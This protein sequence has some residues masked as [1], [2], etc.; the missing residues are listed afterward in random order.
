MQ[1]AHLLAR[2]Q[3]YYRAIMRGED[4]GDDEEEEEEEGEGSEDLVVVAEE[5]TTSTLHGHPLA[6]E[7][8]QK[9]GCHTVGGQRDR[10][11]F[12]MLRQRSVSGSFDQRQRVHATQRM[13]PRSMP[14]LAASGS[15]EASGGDCHNEVSTSR[16]LA[17]YD[18][19]VF[20]GKYSSDG[21]AFLS[22]CQD[23]HIRIYNAETWK[24]KKDVTARHFG[25]SILDV[26][27]SPD[28]RF[29]I[30]SSWADYIQLCNVSG[31]GEEEHSALDL[32]PQ[33]RRFCL[34]SIQ[35]SQSSSEILAGASDQCMYIYDLNT[36]ERV[37]R[38]LA[39]DDDVNAV[40]WADE[41]S[42][43]LF[44]GSDD[45]L[46]KVWD[47]RLLNQENPKPVGTLVGHLEGITHVCSKRDSRYLISNSKDQSIKLW[48]LRA[49][50]NSDAPRQGIRRHPWDYRYGDYFY[51]RHQRDIFSGRLKHPDD[52]SLKTYRGHRVFQTLIRCYFSPEHSTGQRYIYTGSYDGSVYVYDVISGEVV[53]KLHGHEATVRDVSWHPF[54]PN[55]VSTSWDGTVRMWQGSSSPL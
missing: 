35:F 23:R 16:L 33:A 42:Q 24:L 20:C 19:Q 40:S 27:Y 5:E 13:V 31:E 49:M 45:C 4:P 41:T 21:S 54:D 47:R 44:S 15:G 51:G 39:H 14:P 2:L 38:L 53:T 29:F 37:L 22:A 48:D 55:I 52:T 30:Y 11:L 10:S 17:E 36:R 25:W 1:E 9:T 12:H 7:L 26:D 18:N 50:T 8:V 3:R 34:F 46:V 32:R 28:Q 43:I 6:Q